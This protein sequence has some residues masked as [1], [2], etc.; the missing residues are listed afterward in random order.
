MDRNSLKYARAKDKALELISTDPFS[1]EWRYLHITRDGKPAFP[2]VGKVILLENFKGALAIWAG[3]PEEVT[4]DPLPNN[5]QQLYNEE[6]DRVCEAMDRYYEER[7][8]PRIIN[9]PFRSSR[10]S[11]TESNDAHRGDISPSTS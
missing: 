3:L 8:L 11:E 7:G 6:M 2:M 9:S 4:S 10:Q 1:G 5:W